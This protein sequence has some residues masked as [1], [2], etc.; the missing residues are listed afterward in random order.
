MN[1]GEDSIIQPFKRTP[2]LLKVISLVI[3]VEG[4]IGFLFFATILVYQLLNPEF[5]SGWGYGHYS[6][7]SLYLIL[8]MYA[9]IHLGMVLSSILLLKQNRKG[10]YLLILSIGLLTLSSYL[11]HGELNWLGVIAGFILL[12]LLLFFV[13]SLK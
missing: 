6:G 5:L 10:L 11:L 12:T 2:F 8:S 9:V 7:S 3:M 1:P 4:I 13:K